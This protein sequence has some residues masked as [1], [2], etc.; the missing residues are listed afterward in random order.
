MTCS[1]HSNGLA[2]TTT[3][4]WSINKQDKHFS[5]HK[6]TLQSPEKT[7]HRSG[8][9]CYE[10]SRW[11]VI[12]LL[13]VF[14]MKLIVGFGREYKKSWSWQIYLGRVLKGK[15]RNWSTCRNGWMAKKKLR[16]WRG[17][18]SI[19]TIYTSKQQSIIYLDNKT[20]N[21]DAGEDIH[22]R[23]NNLSYIV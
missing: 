3:F 5:R 19:N 6:F 1:E 15:N 22:L 9:I 7:N 10:S 2:S 13:W 11:Y 17:S 14:R 23:K 12:N 16:Y 20:H 4:T 18:S 21:K 8:D